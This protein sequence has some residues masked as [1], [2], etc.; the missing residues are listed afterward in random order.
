MMYSV[1]KTEGGAPGTSKH[2][3]GL[4]IQEFPQLLD[5]G[6]QGLGVVVL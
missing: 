2:V 1:G 6:H 3:P 5:V 4:D